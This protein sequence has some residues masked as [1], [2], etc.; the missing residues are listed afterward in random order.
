VLSK[1][2]VRYVSLWRQP[3]RDQVLPFRAEPLPSRAADNLFWAGRYVERAE[4]TARLLRA[5]YLLRRELRDANGEVPKPY[6]YSLLRALTH[7]TGTYPGFV[8]EGAKTLLK[9][10]RAELHSLLQDTGRV[11]SLA[12][13]LQSFG[14]VALSV[15]DHWP[16]EIWRVIDSIRQDWASDQEAPGPGSYRMDD[17]LDHLIMQLVAFSGLGA[18]SMTRESGWMLLDIGRRLE[19]ALGLI[20][21]LRATLVP[22]MDDALQRQLMETVLIICDSLNT[23][24]RRPR[25]ARRTPRR[26]PPRRFGDRQLGISPRSRAGRSRN[27]SCRRRRRAS[28]GR[29]R[30]RNSGSPPDRRSRGPCRGPVAGGYRGAFGISL[31]S[32][33]GRLRRACAP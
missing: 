32:R 6:L 26:R 18:E 13:T 5:I 24:R 8:G 4:G 15:R 27:P 22:V 3:N 10:P 21:L 14:Q 16:A 17:R 12:S 1:G 23:F 20:S 33:A 25:R 29:S 2:P 19:R 11:G 28:R 9:K 7:V 30:A 31:R